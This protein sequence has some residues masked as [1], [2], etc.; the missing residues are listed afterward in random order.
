MEKKTALTL[1]KTDTA[2]DHTKIHRFVV[3]KTL[4]PGQELEWD[5]AES[6]VTIVPEKYNV[7]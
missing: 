4:H 3:T 2:I 1:I 5:T 7:A 6:E